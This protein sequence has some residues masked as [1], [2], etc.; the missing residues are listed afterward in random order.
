[1]TTLRHSFHSI[2]QTPLQSGASNR[3]R[4]AAAS[5]SIHFGKSSNN[6]QDTVTKTAK[7]A[8]KQA[9]KSANTFQSFI[10]NFKPKPFWGSELRYGG[11]VMLREVIPTAMEM[12]YHLPFAGFVFS[13]FSTIPAKVTPW[14]ADLVAQQGQ[15][16]CLGYTLP[17]L[18]AWKKQGLLK[19]VALPNADKVLTR[20]DMQLLNEPK[21]QQSLTELAESNKIPKVTNGPGRS[22][23]RGYTLQDL[24]KFQKDG[25][26]KGIKITLPD[27]SKALSADD[28]AKLSKDD[29]REQLQELA[30]A[31]KIRPPG[32]RNYSFIRRTERLLQSF[33]VVN[34]QI[35]GLADKTTKQ[36]KEGLPQ[37]AAY[38]IKHF[39]NELQQTL[40]SI[41]KPTLG[42]SI[43][44]NHKKGA[45]KWLTKFLEIRA[46]QTSGFAGQGKFARGVNKVLASMNRIGKKAIFLKFIMF[47]F[48]ITLEGLKLFETGRHWKK[49]VSIFAR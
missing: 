42:L 40:K 36:A 34:D 48:R 26:F 5:S 4:P 44:L 38:A 27:L 2:G 45:G 33:R 24:H 25:H 3:T 19:N 46:V 12:A 10:K 32:M 23:T 41:F 22:V 39:M 9:K 14:F 29:L 28:L 43:S 30:K 49:I 35:D 6:V 47:P 11:A 8:G 18:H 7:Q 37:E 21:L 17:E 15:P 1:M 20:K 16:V 31:K 13:L